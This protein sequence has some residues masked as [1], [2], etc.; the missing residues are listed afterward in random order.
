MT[1]FHIVSQA[2][3]HFSCSQSLN[4]LMCYKLLQYCDHFSHENLNAK[5]IH[6]II[7]NNS[8]SCEKYRNFSYILLWLEFRIFTNKLNISLELTETSM[9]NAFSWRFWKKCTLYIDFIYGNSFHC[10]NKILIWKQK[11]KWRKITILSIS[12]SKRTYDNLIKS[13]L[14]R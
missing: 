3:Y 2:F 9:E 10:W 6:W 8:A 7:L 5:I 14:W 11:L 4:S 13:N 1:L 12:Y